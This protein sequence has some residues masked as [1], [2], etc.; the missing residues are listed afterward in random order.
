MGRKKEEIFLN[1]PVEIDLEQIVNDVIEENSKL[2]L[3]YRGGIAS[4]LEKMVSLAVKKS[5][6]RADPKKIRYMIASK[7]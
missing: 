7:L 6:G 3:E 2:V 5:W 1:A 4:A